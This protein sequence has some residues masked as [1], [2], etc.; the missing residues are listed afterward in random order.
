MP[1]V[2]D[3][4]VA[5]KRLKGGSTEL[6]RGWYRGQVVK[7][8]VFDETA[9]SAAG[10]DTVPVSPIYVTFNVNPDQPF[11]GFASGFRIEA[12][13]EQIHNVPSTLPDDAGYSPLWLVSVYDNRD[14]PTVHDLDT[15]LK[16]KILAPAVATVNCPIVALAPCRIAQ[17]RLNAVLSSTAFFCPAT[18]RARAIAGVQWPRFDRCGGACGEVHGDGDRTEISGARRRLAA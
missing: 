18:R 15:V 5:R 4:S 13:S 12:Q 1:V 11:G 2:P 8:F 17:S 7:Y 9:L 14:W 10:S 6:Q 3:K 16:A